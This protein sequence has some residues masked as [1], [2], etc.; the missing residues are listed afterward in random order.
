MDVIT[1]HTPNLIPHNQYYFSC[2]C[3]MF[4]SQDLGN[5]LLNSMWNVLFYLTEL[6]Q[7]EHLRSEIHTPPM[8]TH[9]SDSH[10]IPWHKKTKWK[11][12]KLSK[13]LILEFS[14]NPYTQH[15]QKL[16]DKMCKYEMDPTSIVGDT[17]RTRFCLQTDGRTDR[18]TD[19][20][21]DDVKPVYPPFNFVEEGG[22]IKAVEEKLLTVKLKSTL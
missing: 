3:N 15:L 14:N 20:Q 17:E 2:H 5:E 19:R 16:L 21:T 13:I 1:P 10:Q 12:Q 11:L 6:V 7:L 9:T 18:C 22:I 8:I 4:F